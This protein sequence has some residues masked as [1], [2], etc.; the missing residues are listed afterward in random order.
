[1]NRVADV[2]NY[3]SK[4]KAPNALIIAPGA[5]PVS[6]GNKTLGIA[7]NQIFSGDDINDTLLALLSVAQNSESPLHMTTVIT[8]SAIGTLTPTK[9]AERLAEPS[10]SFS[11][12]VRG[13]GRFKVIFATQRGSRIVY[14]TRIPVDIPE[15]EIL[16]DETGDS[17]K[18]LDIL[19][20]GHGGVLPFVGPDGASNNT[21]VYAFL[22]TLNAS[23]HKVIYIIERTLTYLMRH[24]NAIVLQSEL[25]SDVPSLDKGIQDAFMFMP[26]LLYIGDVRPSD[27]VPS[28]VPFAE[29]GALVALSSS[30]ISGPQI[31]QKHQPRFRESES[32]RPWT[33]D[34]FVEIT[35]ADNGKLNLTLRHLSGDETSS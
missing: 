20:A 16:L 1:M 2:L 28:L 29:A 27:Q 4:E 11:F 10:G 26:D 23:E 18:V 12:G 6:R 5:P 8:P 3:L 14:I 24:D 33:G 9:E 25:A 15:L 17:G 7:L 21:V 13:V 35:P 34:A 19:K 30:T 22:Q 32:L 31:L